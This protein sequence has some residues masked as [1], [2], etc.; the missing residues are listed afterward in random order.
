[1]SEGTPPDAAEAEP[2]ERGSGVSD[3]VRRAVAAGFEKAGRSKD[4]VVRAATGEIRNW[5]DH[6]ELDNELR[7]ALANMVLE[8]KAEVRF[9]PTEDG[10]IEPT[11][12]ADIK[13]RTA[14]KP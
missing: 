3:F 5:L 14:V 7:K 10:K 11:G 9:R 13:V 1:M 6:L 8:I 12:D 4:D 2:R